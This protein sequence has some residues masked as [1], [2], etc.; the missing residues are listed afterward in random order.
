[1]NEKVHQQEQNAML[2]LLAIVVMV[3]T[4]LYEFGWPAVG[5]GLLGSLVCVL[6]IVSGLK[7]IDC[8]LERE[9]QRPQRDKH[10]SPLPN[11]RPR[12]DRRCYREQW[13]Q[14]RK[15][16]GGNSHGRCL[17]AGDRPLESA[18]D[19]QGNVLELWISMALLTIDGLLGQ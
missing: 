6:L 11:K 10:L 13:H 4:Y 12:N 9:A 5:F 7:N 15:S 3:L 18:G 1:M 16:V 14:R 8:D 2:F 19:D 17:D